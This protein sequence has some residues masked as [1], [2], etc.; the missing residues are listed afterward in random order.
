MYKKQ[1]QKSEN[2]K[3][4]TF[5]KSEKKIFFV[6][7]GTSLTGYGRVKLAQTDAK[8]VRECLLKK[9]AVQS[10]KQRSVLRVGNRQRSGKQQTETS[11]TKN[12]HKIKTWGKQEE[13]K[14][15]LS[16]QTLRNGAYTS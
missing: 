3:S 10:K 6:N 11:K 12:W 8:A 15:L 5:N 4:F 1:Q 2:F 9:R 14:G 13:N 16:L 7:V